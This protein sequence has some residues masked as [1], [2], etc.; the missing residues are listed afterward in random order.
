MSHYFLIKNICTQLNNSIDMA[1]YINTN[2]IRSSADAQKLCITLCNVNSICYNKA[3][4]WS[5]HVTWTLMSTTRL[6]MYHAIKITNHER[7]L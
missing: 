7:K 4:S 1:A 3:K 5:C 2:Q 6:R